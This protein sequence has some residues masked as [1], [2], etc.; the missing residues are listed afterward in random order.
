MDTG[1]GMTAYSVIEQEKVEA[2][3]AAKPSA[4]RVIF[5]EATGISKYKVRRKE[6]RARLERARQALLRVGDRV[7]EMERQVRRDEKALARLNEV[8]EARFNN[9]F[10]AVRTNFQNLFARFLGGGQADLELLPPEAGP[11]GE[12]PDPLDVGI[13]FRIQ[14]PEKKPMPLSLLS[15]EERSLCMMALLLAL[16]QLKPSPYCILDEVDGPLSEPRIDVLMHYIRESSEA[17]RF[18]IISRNLR[19]IA[20]VDRMWAV[21]HDEPGVSGVRS[22]RFMDFEKWAAERKRGQ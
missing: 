5:E 8:S 16:A 3:L 11:N 6:I 9:T 12:A 22:L 17:T 1:V 4:R 18:V 19:T 13:E 10:T 15:G 20:Q 2:L 7:D 14:P 21:T